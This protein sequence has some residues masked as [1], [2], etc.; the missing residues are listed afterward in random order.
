MSH[1]QKGLLFTSFHILFASI[2]TYSPHRDGHHS[3][4]WTCITHGGESPVLVRH[5]ETLLQLWDALR[6]S[7]CFASSSCIWLF[8]FM[9]PFCIAAL[10]AR[11]SEEI[12]S[13]K[14]CAR[15]PHV[16][17]AKFLGMVLV[18]W[19]HLGVWSLKEGPVELQSSDVMLGGV[20]QFF[21][22]F[23]P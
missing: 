23:S 13:G 2:H 12:E 5:G 20:Q 11:Q 4:T 17:N 6:S 1:E 14:K 16:D 9:L 18:C 7:N 15:N 3:I 10:R 8:A 21:F 22:H 19:S